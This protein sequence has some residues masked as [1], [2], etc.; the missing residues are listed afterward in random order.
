MSHFTIILAGNAPLGDN[1]LR[2][3]VKVEFSASKSRIVKN[4]RA[5]FYIN[6]LLR[7]RCRHQSRSMKSYKKVIQIDHQTNP[8]LRAMHRTIDDLVAHVRIQQFENGSLDLFDFERDAEEQLRVQ[9][10]SFISIMSKRTKK[11]RK[12]F[13][14]RKRKLPS[15]RK[16]RQIS[17]DHN[18]VNPMQSD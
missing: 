9:M 8:G 3:R 2:T 16:L 6:P 5:N 7:I 15:S 11:T 13:G 18:P 14:I 10:E 17:T 12:P 1:S 4:L